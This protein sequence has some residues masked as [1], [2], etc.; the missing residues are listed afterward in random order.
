MRW[1]VITLTKGALELGLKIKS[2]IDNVDLYSNPKWSSDQSRPTG[3][4]FNEFISKIFHEYDILVFIMASGI[5][6][7]S[8]ANLIINKTQD[9]GILVMDEKGKYV[10]SLLSGHLGG[11]NDAARL[12]SE[13]IGSEPVITTA[14]DVIGSMAVDNLAM[15]LGCEIDNMNTAKEI[16]SNIVNGY[17]IGIFTEIPINFS[18]PDNIKKINNLEEIDEYSGIIIV[19]NKI[20]SVP[21]PHVRLVPKNIV[22]GLGAKKGILAESIISAIKNELEANNIDPRSIKKIATIDIKKEDKD[23]SEAVKYFNLSLEYIKKEDILK[24][25]DKFEKSDFVK[26]SIGVGAVCEPV[27]YLSSSKKGRFISKKKS[28]DGITIAIWEEI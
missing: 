14:S 23:L 17:K 25:E 2:V 13:K 27:A 7:R 9:P 1:A 11:A 8:I 16:T 10:I 5:V 12:L 28:Y 22:L 4:N 26:K 20:I 18:I 15:F 6:V 3:S 19:S 24:I 21:K